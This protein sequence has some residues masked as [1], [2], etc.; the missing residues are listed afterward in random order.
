M[1]PPPLP[2]NEAQRLQALHQLHVL[3]TPAND[4]FDRLTQM[5]R[6]LFEA[7]IALISLVDD[8]RQWFKSHPGLETTETSRQISF[9]AHAVAANQALI[10]HD[11]RADPRFIDHPLVEAF[12]NIRFYAGHPLR[13]KDNLPVGTFCVIDSQPRTFSARDRRLLENLAGQAEELLRQH[14]LSND[15]ARIANRFEALFSSSAVGKVRVDLQ[16]KIIAVNSAALDMLGYRQE[17]VVGHNVA[18]LT[19]PEIAL[20]HDTFIA[21]FLAGAAPKVI[22]KGREVE[23][24][25]KQG[26][27]VPVH[28]AIN[29]IHD[30]RGEVDEFLGVLTDLSEIHA[31]HQKMRKEQSLLRILHQGITDY[32]ALMSGEQLWTFLMEALRE[33]TDSDYALIGEVLPTETTNALKIH[34][35]TDLSWNDR[36]RDLMVNLRTGNMMLTNPDTLLGRVFA[37]GEVIMTDDVSHHPHSGGFPSGHPLLSNYLGVP[38]T[39][40]DKLIGMYAISN[41]QQTLD[42]ELLQW[43]Q[44]FTDTCALLINLYRQMAERETVMNELAQ[45]KTQAEKANAA[46]SEFLSSM[47]HELRTPLNSILGFAQLLANGKRYPLSAKQCRQVNQIE[48]SG[49]HLLS[50]INE[51]L[52][53]A[54]IEAGH[55][56]LSLETLCADSVIKDA[57]DTLEA[58]AEAA[59]ITLNH[60]PVPEHWCIKADYTRTKQILLNLVSNAIKYNVAQGSVSVTAQRQDNSLRI[61]V[62]DSGPGIP[63]DRQGELF[64]PFNRLDAENGAIEGTGI[65]LAITRELVQRMGGDIGVDSEPAKGSTFWF[66]LPLA[67]QALPAVRPDLPREESLPKA[68]RHL[69]LLYIE[70][71]PANQ[72]LMEDIIDDIDSVVMQIAPSAEIG[73]DMMRSRQPDLVLIDI[74]LPGMDGY[75]ALNAIRHDPR[76]CDLPIIALSANAMPGDAKK[77][78]Q[79]GFN[80]YLTKPLEITKLLD[81]FEHYTLSLPQGKASWT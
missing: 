2:D 10:V 57:C 24:L 80:D 45:A 11:T 52:D 33:L 14:Q 35:I 78:R 44:P 41:S 71:N 59:G 69:N 23:A 54:K 61:S 26:H 50:L 55:L 38:I 3:D 39:S 46:K 79:A 30:E 22:G 66:T 36:S 19:P 28:L 70:D 8:S 20:Y 32:Q 73:L 18:M 1:Q 51:V 56:P 16:G 77:G 60:P 13:P 34:A 81:I 27:C 72:R 62:A 15:L 43:L 63:A 75:Q 21:Q 25:H 6:E 68:S 7:P 29:A 47:S 53:L 42:Q 17:D 64:E 5:A 31:T 67:A 40:G 9:C 74:H 49:Q 48:K 4:A 37:Y 58:S 12:P 76:L 65:G